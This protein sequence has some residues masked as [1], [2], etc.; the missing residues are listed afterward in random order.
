MIHT[1]S[2]ADL[3]RQLA[4][5]VI[6]GLATGNS[7]EIDGLGI[8]H[9]DTVI[10]CRFE[11]INVPQV[12]IAY[13]K[14]DARAANRLYDALEGAGFRPWMDSRKLLPGQNWPRAIENAIEASDFFVACFSSASVNKKGGFQAEIRYALEC[15]RHL[16]LDDVFI[17]PVRLNACR[18]PRLIQRELQ[19]ID[20]FPNWL[21]GIDH[22]V[23]AMHEELERRRQ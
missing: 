8:F 4:Q 12:F 13:A 6:R 5:I 17:I 20:L 7:V 21:E 3:A 10:G 19:Y 11:A 18:V 14:E 1:P 9:P 23:T 15:T 16:P 22:V 2:T